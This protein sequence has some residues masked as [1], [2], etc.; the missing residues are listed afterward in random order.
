[1]RRFRRILLEA[2]TLLSLLLCIGATVRWFRTSD[3]GPGIRH[4]RRAGATHVTDIALF[5]PAIMVFRMDLPE[6]NQATVA[7]G[8]SLHV[9][10]LERNE[11][12]QT[13][14]LLWPFLKVDSQQEVLGVFALNGHV[15]PGVPVRVTIVPLRHVAILFSVP[16]LARAG[17]WCVKWWRRRRRRAG[18]ARPC[19]CCG[20]DCR[21]T[22]DRCPECG[23]EMAAS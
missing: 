10:P 12:T 20:Y 18:D 14:A 1:V 5:G 11:V 6:G 8:W 13:W 17:V 3:W 4:V 16:P 23:R 22:P 15:L 2:A 9:G 7:D 21:A 19:P